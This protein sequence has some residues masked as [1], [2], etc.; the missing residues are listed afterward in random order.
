MIRAIQG[1]LNAPSEPRSQFQELVVINLPT[2]RFEL[3]GLCILPGCVVKRILL[4]DEGGHV[5]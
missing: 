4:Q 3:F 1:T 2:E 5:S